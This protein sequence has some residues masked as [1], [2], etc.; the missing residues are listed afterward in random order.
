LYLC[1]A[2]ALKTQLLLAVKSIFYDEL[3]DV[4]IGYANISTLT[5]LKHLHLTYNEIHLN[6]LEKNEQNLE[7]LWDPS[8]PIKLIWKNVKECC[9]FTAAG[10]NAISKTITVTKTLSMF[11]KTGVL[12][13]GIKDWV[14]LLPL[15]EI[16]HCS[17]SV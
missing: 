2:E 14:Q 6:Q 15:T 9:R 1:V 16:R 8:D 11:E 10:H 12:A 13:E 7:C 5:I 17:S 4:T 3:Y